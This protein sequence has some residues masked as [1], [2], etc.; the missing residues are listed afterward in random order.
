NGIE[1]FGV[2]ADNSIHLRQ[3]NADAARESCGMAFQRSARAERYD[4]CPMSTAKRDDCGDLIGALS[5]RDCVWGMGRMVGFVFAMLGTDRHRSGEAVA[6][7]PP[8]LGKQRRIERR[9]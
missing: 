5:E 6:E 3:V 7:E 8:Q 4:R 2:N 1:I 9:A